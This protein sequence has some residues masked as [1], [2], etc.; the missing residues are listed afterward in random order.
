[1]ILLLYQ[2]NRRCVSLLHVHDQLNDMGM[3]AC[4]P[5]TKC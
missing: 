3:N 1:M 4:T 2:V 5:T